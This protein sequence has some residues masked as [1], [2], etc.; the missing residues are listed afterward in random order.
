M[1]AFVRSSFI[2]CFTKLWELDAERLAKAVRELLFVCVTVLGW[3]AFNY[4]T[5]PEE[6]CGLGTISGDDLEMRTLARCSFTG[7]VPLWGDLCLRFFLLCQGR[8]GILK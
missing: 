2:S 3:K 8:S 4:F 6:A 7:Q 5:I 1:F